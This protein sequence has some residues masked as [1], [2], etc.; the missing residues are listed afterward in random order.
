M[1]LFYLSFLIAVL[2]S[3]LYHVFQ[4]AISPQVNPVISLLVTYITA[5]GGTLLL[6]FIFPL[7]KSIASAIGQVNWASVALGVAIVGLEIGFLLAYR[8]GWDI[9]VTGIATN[10]AAALVLVPTGL[11]IFRERPSTINLAGV[12]VCIF[13][14]VMVNYRK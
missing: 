5:F 8:A 1:S 2:S 12:V 9:S 14:L 13:G 3:V 11:L 7:R 4:R 6:L 10:V